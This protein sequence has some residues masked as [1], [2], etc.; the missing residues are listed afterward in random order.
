MPNRPHPGHTDAINDAVFAP[1]GG[2]ILIFDDNTALLWDRDGKPLATPA[3]H[4]CD[5]RRGVRPDRRIL[6]GSD[7]N[8]ARLWDRD[9]KPLAISR[10]TG[11]GHRRCSRRWRSHPDRFRR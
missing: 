8:T 5:Q 7:D 2:R 10:A 4:R 3:G 11:A 6:T 1:D 9:G